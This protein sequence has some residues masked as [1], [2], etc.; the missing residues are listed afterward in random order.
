MKANEQGLAFLCDS[1]WAIHVP[2][3]RTCALIQAH[4]PSGKNALGSYGLARTDPAHERSV[5]SG[6]C[7]GE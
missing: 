2:Q 6:P 7:D 5:V 4:A 3:C 1:C